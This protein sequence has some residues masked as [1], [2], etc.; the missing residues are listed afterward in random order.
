MLL[1]ADRH[2]SRVRAE[3]GPRITETLTSDILAII[4]KAFELQ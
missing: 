4:L 3:R 1:I 2:S